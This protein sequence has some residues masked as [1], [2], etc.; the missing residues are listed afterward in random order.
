MR[1]KPGPEVAVIDS[2]PPQALPITAEIA[3]ISSSI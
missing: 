1:L 3:A 2:K